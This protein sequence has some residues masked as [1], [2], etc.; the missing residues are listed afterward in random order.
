MKL[1]DK[2]KSTK[3]RP[4]EVAVITKADIRIRGKTTDGSVKRECR[5]SYEAEYPDKSKLIFYGFDIGRSIFR[6]EESDGQMTLDEWLL[7]GGK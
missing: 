6:V 1:G 2:V 3:V 7:K 5:S 4:G